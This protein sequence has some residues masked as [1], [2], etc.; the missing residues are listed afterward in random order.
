MNATSGRSRFARCAFL[1][2]GLV[3]CGTLAFGEETPPA[4][5]PV[6]W[7]WSGDPAGL[8]NLSFCQ[9]DDLYRR[10]TVHQIPNGWMSGHII[11]FTNMAA[12]N[13]VKRF[14][15]RHW[16]G[17]QVEPNGNFINQ[18]RHRRGRTSH[19]AIGPSFTDGNPS[20]L[21]EYPRL[22]PIFGATRDE[23]REIAPGLFLVK[24]YRRVPHVKFL[25]FS[26]LQM[27]NAG[28][29]ECGPLKTAE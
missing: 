12:P 6:T 21:F 1:L 26:Y 13:A 29:W 24:M 2:V 3:A 14:A 10:S 25:G 11:G 17:K 18:W 19:I 23:V 8:H 27:N 20:I 22:T 5:T 15:D 28:C 9:L 7:V 4:P 16:M